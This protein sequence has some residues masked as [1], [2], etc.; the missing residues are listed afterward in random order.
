MPEPLVT[1]AGDRIVCHSMRVFATPSGAMRYQDQAYDGWRSYL[2]STLDQAILAAV[3]DMFVNGSGTSWRVRRLE[4][5]H[6]PFLS[7]PAKL[8]QIAEECVRGSEPSFR[9]VNVQCFRRSAFSIRD[10]LE[11]RYDTM[12]WKRAGNHGN[13]RSILEICFSNK[14][15]GM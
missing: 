5:G 2:H 7:Q 10:N 15:R 3:Q 11:E 8:A 14:L 9:E 13:E 6:N 1:E 12:T 4:M